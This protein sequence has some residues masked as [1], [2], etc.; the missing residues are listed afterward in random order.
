MSQDDFSLFWQQAEFEGK[1]KEGNLKQFYQQAIQ[2]IGDNSSTIYTVGL[3]FVLLLNL[4]NGTIV[5]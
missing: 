4:I 1:L 3:V 2:M 5:I